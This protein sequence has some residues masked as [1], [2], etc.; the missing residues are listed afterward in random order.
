MPPKSPQTLYDDLERLEKDS[1][2]ESAQYREQAQEILADTAVSL[3][4]RQ[5]IADRLNEANR[6]LGLMGTDPEE[7]Y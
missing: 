3:T 1:V 2:I 6:D 4:W 7:S 5:A